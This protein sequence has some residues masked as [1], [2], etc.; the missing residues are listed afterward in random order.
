MHRLLLCALLVFSSACGDDGSAADT[1]TGSDTSVPVDSGGD[2]GTADTGTADTSTP[3]DT[4]TPTDSSTDTAAGDGGSGT[5]C[6]FNSDCPTAERCE[7]DEET[8]CFCATGTRGTGQVGVDVCTSGNDCES[9]VCVEGP[10][11]TTF[12]CSTECTDD[13]DCDGMLPMCIDVAFVGRIC[14][15]TP[16]SP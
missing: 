15:R 13:G 16:P 12:Y 14:V 8:G 10:D 9:A 7:C 3:S 4:G 6:S 5:A 2:T 11:D 1:G